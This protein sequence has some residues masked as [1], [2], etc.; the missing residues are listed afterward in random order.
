MSDGQTDETK[1]RTALVTPEK[2][3]G[4]PGL[5]WRGGMIY[6]RVR[7]DGK[8][9]FRCTS[10]DKIAAARKVLAKWRE[11]AVMRQHGIEPRV[12]VIALIYIHINLRQ[13]PGKDGPR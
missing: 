9:T 3:A 13:P 6:A 11:D 5:Y 7:V 2:I 10:T 8:Q 1:Q 12:G 4:E